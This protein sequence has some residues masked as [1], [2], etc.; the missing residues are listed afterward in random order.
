MSQ[1]H[2]LPDEALRARLSRTLRRASS[3]IPWEVEVVSRRSDDAGPQYGF[4]PVG[5]D[6]PITV[7]ITPNEINNRHG[8]G[9]I[10]KRI[11]AGKPG[12]LSIRSRSDWGLHDFG[13]WQVCLS[14]APGGRAEIFQKVLR[15]LKGRAI[16]NVVC[17]PFLTQDLITA[18]ALNACFG[19][20]LCGYIMDDQNVAV[21]CI[22][23]SIMG[24][25][26]QRCSLR[27]VTHPE[28]RS[29]YESKYDL[30]FHLL[31]AV[32]PHQLIPDKYSTAAAL[33]ADRRAAMIG[34]IWD[35]S[36]FDSLC[37]IFT[38]SNWHIDWYGNNKS[39]YIE[40]SSIKLARSGIIPHGV[41]PEDRLV[42]ELCTYPFVIVPVSALDD[43]E[44]NHGVSQLSLPGR[45]LFAVATAGIPVLI[46]G[47]ERTCASRFVSHFGVGAT[48]PYR[49]MDAL[50][51]MS[52]LLDPAIQS[53][54]RKNIVK[55]AHR[56]SDV[57]I[58]SWLDESIAIGGPADLRFEELFTNYG[59][60]SA[61]TAG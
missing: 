6:Q 1:L 40:M 11:L 23:D 57:D 35:K 36:W 55:I 54:I 16:G 48:T 8:T 24:E 38:G 19:A 49:K 26:L 3:Q 5:Y 50:A 9:P 58:V 7:I 15:G 30:P 17:I 4:P 41:I 39:P 32:A 53:E 21:N 60:T 10:I 51:I 42:D 61:A 45:I 52:Q 43:R 44:S 27:L 37:E 2:T 59:G 31:P 46:I 29:A 34:S 47:S 18:I 33:R 14:P 20:R 12:I 56:L 28:L 25:F 13:Q 22:P